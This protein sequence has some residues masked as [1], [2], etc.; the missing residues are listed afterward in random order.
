MNLFFD[1]NKQFLKE[2]DV[3]S[4]NLPPKSA[5]PITKELYQDER[6][7]ILSK[8]KQLFGK[9][10]DGCE[11]HQIIIKR[12]AQA[13]YKGY[14]VHQAVLQELLVKDR[15][16]PK[17]LDRPTYK[18]A[19]ISFAK[20]FKQITASSEKKLSHIETGLAVWQYFYDKGYQFA[21]PDYDEG[22]PFDMN[23]Y[24]DD[25]TQDEMMS[26]SLDAGMNKPANS[27]NI[28]DFKKK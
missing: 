9:R 25:E 1:L 2:G 5:G 16:F 8:A 4:L 24:D 3:V 13:G 7:L 28:L 17:D 19:D 18:E 6:K 22:D 21:T 26:M 23:I 27:N 14:K 20:V 11:L 15:R 10:P 12:L